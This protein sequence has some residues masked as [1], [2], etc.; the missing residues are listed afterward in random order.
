MPW[1]VKPD[2]FR[3]MD[4]N[5][6]CKSQLPEASS[7]TKLAP[8][9]PSQIPSFQAGSPRFKSVPLVQSQIP[10]TGSDQVLQV[11]TA[12]SQKSYKQRKNPSSW[13]QD[14]LRSAP[15]GLCASEMNQSLEFSAH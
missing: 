8:L 1:H 9:V 14:N 2:G 12:I 11:T 10:L 5:P 15:C 3:T 13:R 6:S 7:H 4:A